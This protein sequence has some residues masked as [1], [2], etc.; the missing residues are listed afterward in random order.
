MA[1]IGTT[2]PRR[3]QAST[4]IAATALPSFRRVAI[5]AAPNP[6]KSGSTMH[7]S[8]ASARKAAAVSGI[9]GM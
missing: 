8:R 6:E 5:A 2:F 9:I 4:V 7:P 3:R 1:F